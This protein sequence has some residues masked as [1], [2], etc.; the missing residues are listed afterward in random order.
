[1]GRLARFVVRYPLLVLVLWAAVVGTVVAIT[2]VGNAVVTRAPHPT[3][4]QR[5]RTL[6]DTAFPATGS[7]NHP[8]TS[9]LLSDPHGITAGEEALVGLA[10]PRLRQWS[11]ADLGPGWN[12][13]SQP[14]VADIDGHTAARTGRPCW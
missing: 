13:P 9:I 11:Y 4:A 2:P 7:G 8:P 3:A 12:P 1:M 10:I 6:L 5:A 14:S